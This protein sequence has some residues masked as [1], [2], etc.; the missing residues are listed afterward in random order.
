MTELSELFYSNLVIGISGLILALAA[1]LYRSKCDQFSLCCG[2][3]SVHRNITAE[4]EN[5]KTHEMPDTHL[6]DLENNTRHGSI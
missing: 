3:V 2:L 5:D 1:I 6:P 4:I